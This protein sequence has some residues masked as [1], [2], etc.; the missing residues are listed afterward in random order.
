MEGCEK[1]TIKTK[2]KR[3]KKERQIKNKTQPPVRKLPGV[4]GGGDDFECCW[5]ARVRGPLV[6]SA[7]PTTS[8]DVALVSAA[9]L[10]DGKGNE[11]VG[12]GFRSWMTRHPLSL[13]AA[14][15]Q[16]SATFFCF[17]DSIS[18]VFHHITNHFFPSSFFLFLFR[19]FWFN[20]IDHR[21]RIS[22]MRHPISRIE[23]IHN[24]EMRNFITLGFLCP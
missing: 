3:K 11:R 19:H 12:N 23:S 9:Y 17:F 21:G 16:P 22:R 5:H 8:I 2:P 18:L 20:Q 24:N 10:L 7:L 1:T 15:V 4:G 13:S 14:C 6:F